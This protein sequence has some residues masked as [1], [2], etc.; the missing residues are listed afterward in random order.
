[1][2][3]ILLQMVNI[4]AILI[5]QKFNLG[6][7]YLLSACK[8]LTDVC[9]KIVF[10]MESSFKAKYTDSSLDAILKLILKKKIYFW[11]LSFLFP[12]NIF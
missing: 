2:G 12:P 6:L 11:L 9:K 7:S 5:K 8:I 4:F 10:S 3:F 1:M